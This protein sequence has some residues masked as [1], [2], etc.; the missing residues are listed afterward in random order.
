MAEP[1]QKSIGLSPIEKKRLDSAKQKYEEA[2]GGKVDFGTFL[3]I[4]TALGLGAI[5]LYKLRRSSRENP[6]AECP[7]C[8]TV[9]AI[10]YSQDLPPVVYV[11]CPECGEELV[12]DFFDR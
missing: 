4:V 1:R 3:G 11:T 2:T 8:G 10:A 7:E 5:G 6:S 9:F 12:I